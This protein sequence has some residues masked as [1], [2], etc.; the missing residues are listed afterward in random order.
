[1]KRDQT[2][3]TPRLRIQPLDS[4]LLRGRGIQIDILRADEVHPLISGNKWFKLKYNLLR[5]AEQ[6]L[7]R[8]LSFGGAYSN[9]IYALAAA[10]RAYGFR[11]IGVIRGEKPEPLNATLGFAEAQGMQLHFVSRE[12]YRHKHEAAFLQELQAAYGSCFIIPEGGSNELAVQGCR[13]MIE[14]PEDYDCIACCV[15]TGGTL[16]GILEKTRNRAQVLGFSALKGGDFLY[17]EVNRLTRACSGHTYDNY[18][19]ITDYHFGGYARAKPEL[20]RFINDFRQMH[21]L[22]LDPIYTG[23]MMYGLLDRVGQELFSRGSRILAVHS[24]GLQGI[25]GFNERFTGKNLRIQVD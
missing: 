19:I 1:M 24:G 2:L 13:E 6:R 16:A 23:K 22:Q 9:H 7:D 15:G 5:A 21:Q 20:V 3:A 17:E 18:R 12:A 14:N 8:L 11:T 10:G 4:P 25:A